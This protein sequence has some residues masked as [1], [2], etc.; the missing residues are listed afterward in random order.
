MAESLIQTE[1]RCPQCE[2]SL[3]GLPDNHRCPECGFAYQSKSFRVFRQRG[4]FWLYAGGAVFMLCFVGA[5][6]LILGR[7]AIH[8]LVYSAVFA[9]V[10]IG[11]IVYEK[12]RKPN[13]IALSEDRIVFRIALSEDRIVFF[14]RNHEPLQFAW[15]MRLSL[16]NAT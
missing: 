14:R 3:E 5:Y 15:G 10:S 9:V 4:Y 16:S 6:C 8:M 1:E 2:Y 13:R 11:Q 7:V 12:C